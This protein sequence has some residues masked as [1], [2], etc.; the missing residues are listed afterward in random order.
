MRDPAADAPA[1]VL[2]TIEQHTRALAGALDV[3]GLLNVQFA[4]KA[5][6]VFVIEANPRASRTVPFVSK[7]TGR[8]A[9]E[10][11]GAVDA[12]RDAGR[13]ARPKVCC[14]R[15]PKVTTSSIKEAVLPFDR[16]PDV[17]TLLG[18]EMRSTGE[19]M[20]ID[21]TFGM[22]FAKSQAGAGN[23]LPYKGTVFLSLADRDKQAGLVAAPPL[24]R[25][26]VL[27]R[28]DRRHRRDPRSERDRGRDG[29]GEGRRGPARRGCD[30]HDLLRQGRPD[31]E[32]AAGPGPAGR[33]PAHP[34]G[35]D[36][37]RRA[38]RHD[39]GRRDRRGSR[40]R[41]GGSREPEVR[42]LQ[43]YHRDGQLRLEV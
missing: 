16:F 12:R 6:E 38:L 20:G 37:A 26:R 24:R 39:G 15:P 29:R 43:S 31:R 34:A 1:P 42:S 19:V 7:A 2:K 33:R 9:R 36:R 14:G 10:G 4:V 23:T 18:P 35:R 41:R 17:D 8:A 13:A 22:A 5:G 21:R 27:V 28:G 25:A 3:V 32:H 11:R 40:D 30:R